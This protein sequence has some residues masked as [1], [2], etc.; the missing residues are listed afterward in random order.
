MVKSA[1]A[2]LRMSTDELSITSEYFESSLCAPLASG[3]RNDPKLIMFPDESCKEEAWSL[4][5]FVRLE[6]PKAMSLNTPL[7]TVPM[8]AFVASLMVAVEVFS[9]KK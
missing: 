3:T 6:P 2:L 5:I 4:V 9:V 8:R 1:M 7:V